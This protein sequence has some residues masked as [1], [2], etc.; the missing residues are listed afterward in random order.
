MSSTQSLTQ[1]AHAE[2][3][4]RVGYAAGI[5]RS[6][7]PGL[8]AIRMEELLERLAWATPAPSSEPAIVP[9]DTPETP[10]HDDTPHRDN[11]PAKGNSAEFKK[12]RKIQAKSSASRL[13]RRQGHS[14]AFLPFSTEGYA[15]V[16]RLIIRKP[17]K[18]GRPFDLRPL[19]EQHL[20]DVMEGNRLYR[21]TRA[22]EWDMKP[23]QTVEGFLDYLR[24]IGYR[25]Q[26]QAIQFIAI[27]STQSDVH[28]RV[29]HMHPLLVLEEDGPAMRQVEK[30]IKL[31]NASAGFTGSPY[32]RGKAEGDRQP[33]LIT[34]ISDNVGRKHRP[35][36]EVKI[37]GLAGKADY[38]T[39]HPRDL[40]RR[41]LDSQGVPHEV[42]AHASKD[43]RA[44]ARR[45]A[46]YGFDLE[47]KPKIETK[48]AASPNMA[49]LKTPTT[50]RSPTWPALVPATEP[51]KDG[52]AVDVVTWRATP[53]AFPSLTRH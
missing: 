10:T 42:T 35:S 29:L 27:F 7:F 24:E 33:G 36:D 43:I 31:R 44:G 13:G 3:A 49:E 2:Q 1:S 28:D 5:A 50:P 51:R 34:A 23:G 41:P 38:L 47:L 16:W 4:G 37:M 12:T 46:E 6:I 52:L 48:P 26:D 25:T 40:K 18:P 17:F 8:D 53:S 15:K 39:H 11:R 30:M 22:I 45:M 19:A 32:K 20:L 9:V 14:T 21:F